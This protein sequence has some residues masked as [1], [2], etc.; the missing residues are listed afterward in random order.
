MKMNTKRRMGEGDPKVWEKM[1]VMV[2]VVVV[3]LM[4][5]KLK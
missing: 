2:T 1:V 5:A 3:M 4:V